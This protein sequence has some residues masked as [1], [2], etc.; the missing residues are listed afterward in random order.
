[1]VNPFNEVNWKPGL[2]ERRKFAVSLMIGFPAV[3]VALL[4][5]GRLHGGT[6]R[7]E[8]PL[9]VGGIGLVAGLV[10]RVLPQIVRP[11]YLG[12][13]SVACSIGF[14]V[15]NVALAGVYLLLFTPIGLVRRAFGRQTFSK[16]FDRGAPT[17]W[18]DVRKTVDLTKYYRQF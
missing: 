3:A 16:G 6:W 4:L 8:L 18:R 9:A 1:M 15:G 5:A 12:W 10:F 14:V 2:P 7:F 13:Y 11:F 17:Y